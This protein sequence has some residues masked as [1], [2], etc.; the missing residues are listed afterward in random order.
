[1]AFKHQTI[2][3]FIEFVWLGGGGG[4]LFKIDKIVLD[5]L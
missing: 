5:F 2:Y 1:M 3:S 4:T